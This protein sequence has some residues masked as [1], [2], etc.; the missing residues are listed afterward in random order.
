MMYFQT[1]VYKL[2][3]ECKDTLIPFYELYGYKKD[4][5]NNFLVQR[6]VGDWEN[7]SCSVVHPE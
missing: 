2:S 3:L 5:G 6:S 4:V 7:L 1:G